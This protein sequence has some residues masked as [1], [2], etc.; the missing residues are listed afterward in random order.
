MP[1]RLTICEAAGPL[2]A[3]NRQYLDQSLRTVQATEGIPIE[4]SEA[5]RLVS[6]NKRGG[7]RM[8]VGTATAR[9]RNL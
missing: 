2:S 7:P 9:A 3:Q 6:G 4:S 5:G 8:F 1:H